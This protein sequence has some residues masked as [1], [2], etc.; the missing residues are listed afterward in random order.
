MTYLI[1]FVT[2][3]AMMLVTQQRRGVSQ[4]MYRSFYLL[5]GA[6]AVG[7]AAVPNPWLQALLGFML[8]NL[9]RDPNVG[10]HLSRALPL[11]LLVLA[12]VVSVHSVN[13]IS[14]ELILGSIVFCGGALTIQ[15]II[16][17][18]EQWGLRHISL[19]AG[20]ENVNNSQA[21]SVICTSA[22]V[23]LAWGFSPWWWLA[24][25]VVALPIV[26][27]QWLDWHMQRSIT[28]GP[29]IL[30]GV[31]IGLLPFAVGWWSALV[32]PF[33]LTG[34]VWGIAQAMRLPKWWDSGRVRIWW[35]MLLAGWW[36]AG[37]S[38]RLFGRGWQ[39]WVGYQDFL[40]DVAK[41]T[42][43]QAIVNCKTMM[44]TAHNEWVQMLF[45]HGAVG[46][47]LLT[48]YVVTG[49][50]QLGHGGT[51]AQAVYIA[52]L[53]VCGVACALH[54]WTWTHGTI[55]E[56]NAQEVPETGGGGSMLYTIG[57]PALNWLSFLVALLVE[58][59][60]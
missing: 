59:A 42:N 22:A 13:A 55:T 4:G 46:M 40:V 21:I 18:N 11:Y 32:L 12:G 53:G 41:R 3:F 25:P 39:S 6:C 51:E 56:V 36:S 1:L 10:V 30:A 24:V 33:V 28:I 37:W 16:D 20:Q 19:H 15:T 34:L 31:G 52:A 26:L 54:P 38:V 57:S 27:I 23:G 2:L 48:G 60:R 29:V 35:M 45:E 8:V 17:A 14:V 9:L 7:L 43:R 58:V 44:S 47:V 50:W 5:G 49:L